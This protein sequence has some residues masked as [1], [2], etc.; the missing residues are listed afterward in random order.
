M[1]DRKTER[2]ELTRPEAREVIA[3]LT[4]YRMRASGED[5]QRLRNVQDRL[6]VEFG[7]DEHRTDDGDGLLTGSEGWFDNDAIFDHD[8]KEE[9]ELSRAEAD[10]VLDALA[11][12]DADAPEN[13]RVA[14][15]VRGR[16]AGKFGSR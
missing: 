13:E 6:E 14:E 7:F 11:S 12:F 16:I 1:T 10:D 9:I 15:D 2:F 5:E 4:N 3:A 8:Q